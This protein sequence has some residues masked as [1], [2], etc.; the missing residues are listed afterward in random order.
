MPSVVSSSYRSDLA[1]LFSKDVYNNDYYLFVSSTS[2]TTVSN[3]NFSKNSFLEKTL[4]GK[5]I[6]TDEIFYMIKNYPWVINTV[7]DQYDD[8]ADMSSLRYY[9]VVYPENNE[10]DDYKIYKCL[11]N[12]YGAESI[13]PP[14]YSAGTTDQIYE[15]GDGYVWKFMY[16]ISV[17]DFDKYNTNGYIPIMSATEEMM[18]ANTS[19]S[20][21]F[22]SNTIVFD[23]AE[24]SEIRQIFVDNLD[25]NVGYEKVSGTITQVNVR[26]VGAIGQRKTYVDSVV[27]QTPTLGDLNAIENYYTGY[28]IYATTPGDDSVSSLHEIDT[29]TYSQSTGTAVIKLKGDILVEDE[30]D[31]TIPPI[32]VALNSSYI[33]VP[34]VKVLGDGTG[35]Q[36]YPI[37][38]D[39]G[40]ILSVEVI[41]PG[42]GYTNA[43]AFVPDPFA[44]DPTSPGSL[45][46]RVELRPVLSSPGGHASNLIN[47]LGCRHVLAYSGITISD[48]NTIPTT[49]DF[50]SLGLVKNPS[51]KIDFLEETPV[52]FD[53]RIAISLDSHS[54]SVNETVTQIDTDQTR[55]NSDFF[56]RVRFS[57][58]VHAISNNTIYL[59]EYM[60]PYPNDIDGDSKPVYANTDFSDVSLDV[61]L[62]IISSQ[63]EILSINTD[64]NPEIPNGFSLSPYVQRTGE[65]YYMSNFFPITRNENS[66][67]Q[68]KILLEF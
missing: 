68:F 13:Y 66:R 1:R 2:N 21:T 42:T 31:E 28:S 3:S 48:N 14:N 47:E 19:S 64:N 40:S 39:T 37:I 35:V 20:N 25:D 38:S 6:T 55:S 32:G 36:A 54:L 7:Y 15:L 33:I 9:A 65:V 10:S 57:A 30:Q 29:Y 50:T 18:G 56:N 24:T 26:T 46:I 51:F 62:P 60:G 53:N 4:F 17:V 22:V 59:C 11:F 23:T 41:Q 49:N 12:N 44:F 27:I 16:S 61:D 43:V 5:K 8:R 45:S 52:V 63:N 58:K 67:E 34:S